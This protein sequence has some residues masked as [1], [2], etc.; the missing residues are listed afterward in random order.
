MIPSP[1]GVNSGPTWH[2]HYHLSCHRI[3][4]TSIQNPYSCN[5]DL[6]GIVRYRSPPSACRRVHQVA[7]YRSGI[8]FPYKQNTSCLK[9]GFLDFR[10][11]RFGRAGSRVF[12]PDLTRLDNEAFSD[13]TRMPFAGVTATHLTF[14]VSEQI[15]CKKNCAALLIN[16]T[17]PIASNINAVTISIGKDLI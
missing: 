13:S 14:L 2:H 15:P 7:V 1:A 4:D 17:I 8:L 3:L 11:S 16:H 10:L 5:C 9:G 12:T 6:S